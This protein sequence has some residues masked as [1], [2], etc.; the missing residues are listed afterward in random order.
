MLERFAGW[1]TPVEAIVGATSESAIN[2]TDVYVRSPIETWGAGRV[3]LL[4]DAAHPMTNSMG[5]GAN[6]AIEDAIVLAR[7]LSEVDDPVAA[8]R[9]YERCRIGRSGS[10][11]KISS[12]MSMLS[13]L[14]Q[15]PAVALR[16]AWLRFS[17]STFVYRKLR[18][19]MAYT[20]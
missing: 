6:Q 20:F 4:G 5:Q 9:E 12:F 16:N 1:R 11:V 10:V 2:R 17:L 8:L 19:D 13:R 3:T 18:S 7:C 15:P 14:Q